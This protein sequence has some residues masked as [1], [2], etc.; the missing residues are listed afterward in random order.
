MS[1]MRRIV[2]GSPV[3]QKPAILREFLNGLHRQDVEGLQVDHVLIDDNSDPASSLL[4]RQFAQAV[5]RV[6]IVPVTT[7]DVYVCDD[8][9]HRWNEALVWKVAQFKDAI[10]DH[11]LETGHDGLFLVDSDLVLHPQ[12]IRH[13]AALR[14]DVVSEVFW[15]RWEPDSPEL[16]QV[17]VQDT[18][19]LVPRARGEQLSR[20]EAQRR[21]LELLARLRTPG[22]YEVGGLGACTMVSR[23]ALERGA[24]FREIPNL[25]FWGEDRHFCIRATAL[26]LVLNA[27]TR[28]PPL[29]LYREQDLARVASFAAASGLQPAA[30][31]LA[32]PVGS[33]G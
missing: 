15:T 25:S 4:L 32:R 24:R 30:D 5:P 33:P 23:R 26:G 8:V 21:L 27:D 14:C 7:A 3:H 1:E 28:L 13:L 16:P 6:T 20:E 12:T 19:D 2:V 31:W 18:Y 17:W 22:L 10:I 11:V 9:T 29:H